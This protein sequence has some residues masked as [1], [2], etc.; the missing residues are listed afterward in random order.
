MQNYPNPFNPTTT[1]Q[2]TIPEKSVVNLSI[3][4]IL[5][6]E[7]NRVINKEL[8]AGSHQY[9]WDAAGLPSGIYIYKLSTDKFTSNKKMLLIK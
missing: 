2:F 6:E 7:V 9:E 8:D 3:Y 4:N 1:I 5:G